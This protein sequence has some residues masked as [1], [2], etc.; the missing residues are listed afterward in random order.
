[1]AIALLIE[2]LIAELSFT[3]GRG[4]AVAVVVQRAPRIS[5]RQ[6][7]KTEHGLQKRES[8][9]WTRTKGV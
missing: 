1:M 2:I 7:G 6:L 8:G 4:S 9:V 5:E 3:I